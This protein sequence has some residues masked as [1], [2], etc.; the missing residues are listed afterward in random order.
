[1]P[2]DI[3]NDTGKGKGLTGTGSGWT[4][5]KSLK[6]EMTKGEGAQ[7]RNLPISALR[8]RLTSSRVFLTGLTVLIS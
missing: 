6:V 2:D 7:V 1:L 3:M 5:P 8:R 4:L